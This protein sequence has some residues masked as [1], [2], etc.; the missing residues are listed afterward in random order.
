MNAI[1]NQLGELLL[2][3]IPTIIFLL[4]TVFTYRVLV[5]KPLRQTLAERYKRT[6]GAVAQAK[7]D[8]AAAEARTT[9]YE[10][11]IREARIT[12]FKAQEQRREQA[13]K[14]RYAAA[15]VARAAAEERLRQHKQQL[16]R[17]AEAAKSTLQQQAESMA[18]EIIR[19]IVNPAG[20]QAG[21]R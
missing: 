12:I 6:E 16:D 18:T 2:G 5:F 8:I 14:T 15:T 20:A 21:A 7:A 9:E 1:L 11:R 4:L 10:Q 3:S 13:L 17:E 19:A